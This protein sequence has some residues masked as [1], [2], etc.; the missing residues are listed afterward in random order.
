VG[1]ILAAVTLM[2]SPVLGQDLEPRFLSPA[3]VGMNFAILSYGLSTGNVVMDAALPL[4]GTV[5]DVN[6]IAATYVRTIGILGTTGRFLAAVP[7]ATSTW[8]GELAGRDSS[9]TRT[10]LSDPLIAIAVNFLGNRA[11]RGVEFARYRPRTVLGLSLRA[12]VPLG[13][14]DSSKL[15]NLSTHRWMVSPRLGLAFYAGRFVFEGYAAVWFFTTNENFF[16]GNT[17]AQDPLYGFQ[18]HVSYTFRSGFWAAVSAGQSFGGQ[19]ALNGVKEDNAQENNRLG[20][21]VAFPLNS[22]HALKAA[23]TSGI[24][25]RAGADF[26]SVILAWQFRWGGMPGKG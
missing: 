25:T 16:G 10:G 20:V 12:R 8:S 14:Y 11:Q 13:Q 5:A 18:G 15:F 21:T 4:E 17:L 19:T 24:T 9:T 3:P 22:Q 26:D 23:F 1:P 2:S 6:S 7:V